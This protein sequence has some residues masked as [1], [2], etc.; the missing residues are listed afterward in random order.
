[1]TEFNTFLREFVEDVTKEYKELAR[2]TPEGDLYTRGI[3]QRI[4]LKRVVKRYR[5]T[6]TGKGFD[7]A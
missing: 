7:A 2:G 6:H 3:L 1:M 5:Y 4:A